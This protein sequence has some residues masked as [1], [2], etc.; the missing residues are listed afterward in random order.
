M[1]YPIDDHNNDMGIAQD[2]AGEPYWLRVHFIFADPEGLPFV[3]RRPLKN[4]PHTGHY[5][6]LTQGAL[7][8][9][10][11]LFN[12]SLHLGRLVAAAEPIDE[13]DPVTSQ[14]LLKFLRAASI[15]SPRI[16]GVS[17]TAGESVW[18]FGWIAVSRW[19]LEFWCYD[20]G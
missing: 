2:W 14:S 3:T 5:V 9:L 7:P 1:P 15:R 6:S 13:Q 4:Q 11:T 8:G 12:V 10:F 20:H 18:I 17:F 16:G 19:S